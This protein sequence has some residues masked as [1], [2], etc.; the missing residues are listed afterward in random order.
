MAEHFLRIGGRII[1]TIAA[2]AL[3]TLLRI[4]NISADEL[5]RELVLQCQ[6]DATLSITRG[7]K[8]DIQKTTFHIALRLRDGSLR[9]IQYDFLEGNSCTLIDGIVRCELAT[10]AYNRKLDTTSQE[11]RSVTIN[12]TNG[13]I[14]LML[15]SQ[16]FVGT[17]TI[18][19]PAIAIKSS[20]IGHC[21]SAATGPLF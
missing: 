9:N 14:N 6:G 15:E 21:H 12:R 5:P 8:N 3:L 11:H 7:N 2:S 13:E 10:T 16:T 20:R 18:G 1:L 17:K 19:E 4:M